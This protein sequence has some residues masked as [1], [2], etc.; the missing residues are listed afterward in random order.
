MQDLIL[1]HLSKKNVQDDIFLKDL[2]SAFSWKQPVLL[3]HD[4]PYASVEETRFLTKKISGHLSEALVTNIG[5][6]G[7]QRSLLNL[8]T[9]GLQI[10]MD[11]LEQWYRM[12]PVL[13]INSLMAS[14]GY[15]PASELTRGLKA[16][17]N[18]REVILFPDNPLSPL[19]SA[20]EAITSEDRIN[21]LLNLYPE[22]QAV[23]TLAAT[24]L[25]VSIRKAR[26]YPDAAQK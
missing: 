8:E 3:V 5:V 18:P 4:S 21:Q 17:L 14:K 16:R 19:A 11:L 10:R 1:L 15:V 13:V 9:E 20:K 6:S 25:P 24:L 2:S 22:E 23:L 7:D 26:E 12:A